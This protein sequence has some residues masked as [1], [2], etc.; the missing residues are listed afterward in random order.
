MAKVREASAPED[1][2]AVRSLFAEYARG[3]DEPRCFAGF[4]REL[5]DLPRGYLVLFLSCEEAVPA[6]CVGL[7]EV[8]RGTAEMKRLYVR[9]AW[10]G[11]GIG[12]A[13]AEAA[14]AAA[15]AAGYARIV[16]DSLPK[17]HEARE[18]YRS[19]DF[20][21]TAPYLA[22]PTPGADCFERRL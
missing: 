3:V 17:M 16:L 20:R 19:L 10:R 8:D 15:R 13:L 9:P 7:R 12:R 14:I 6:G 2:D 21:E 11:R 5:A 1:L 4:E 18:L 22:Q